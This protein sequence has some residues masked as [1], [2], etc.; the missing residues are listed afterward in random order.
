[1]VKLKLKLR[2]KKKSKILK[3]K[4][5]KLQKKESWRYCKIWRKFRK[6]SKSLCLEEVYSN[7][8]RSIRLNKV[9]DLEAH[10]EELYTWES[11]SE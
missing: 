2:K 5:G 3:K 9:K 8:R 4:K 6:T 10:I 1:M 11:L 7:L